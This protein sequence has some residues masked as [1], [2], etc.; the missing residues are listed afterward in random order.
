MDVIVSF[1]EKIEALLLDIVKCLL[2]GCG[3]LAS[4][5]KLLVNFSKTSFGRSKAFAGTSVWRCFIDV[6]VEACN[7]VFKFA[8]GLFESIDGLLLDTWLC[9]LFLDN[10]KLKC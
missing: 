8:F 10:C 5:I 1:S 2:C 4:F 7:V 9:I 3:A 6:G